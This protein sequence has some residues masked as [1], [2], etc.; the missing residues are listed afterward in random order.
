MHETIFISKNKF[1]KKLRLVFGTQ[2]TTYKVSFKSNK[3]KI[4]FKK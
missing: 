4:P 2:I 1:K 3:N